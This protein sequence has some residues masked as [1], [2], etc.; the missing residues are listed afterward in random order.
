MLSMVQEQ[1]KNY[2]LSMTLILGR[3][4]KNQFLKMWLKLCTLETSYLNI[5]QPLKM[6]RTIFGTLLGKKNFPKVVASS[7]IWICVLVSVTALDVYDKRFLLKCSYEYTPSDDNQL[8]LL[9]VE[10]R[11]H[12]LHAFVNNE[13]VGKYEFCNWCVYTIF[14]CLTTFS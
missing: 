8:V 14:V 2:S 12:I 5:W 4:S 7:S 1:Q 11:A 13:Y 3:H 9:N 6:R 10:S